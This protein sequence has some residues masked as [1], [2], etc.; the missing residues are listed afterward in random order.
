MVARDSRSTSVAT[1]TFATPKAGEY[2]VCYRLRGHEYRSVGVLSVAAVLPSTFSPTTV[3][4]GDS[5]HLTFVGKGL[6]AGSGGDAVKVVAPGANCTSANET[7]MLHEGAVNGNHTHTATTTPPVDLR[8]LH[9]VCYRLRGHE[10]RSVGVLSVAAVLPSTFS[11]AVVFAGDVAR[12]SFVGKGL[13]AGS[14][15]DA[16]KVVVSGANC[17]SANAMQT[18]HEGAVHG[19]RT[20][21]N[22]VMPA[23]LTP[24][25]HV[26]CYC[27]PSLQCKGLLPVLHVVVNFQRNTK[28]DDDA[29]AVV[30]V[31]IVVVV[32]LCAMGLAFVSWRRTRSNNVDVERP[33]NGAGG[34]TSGVATAFSSSASTTVGPVPSS[35]ASEAG[36]SMGPASVD[37]TVVETT[38]VG[39][40]TTRSVSSFDSTAATTNDD[41]DEP[42]TANT[43]AT[44]VSTQAPAS[45][46]SASEFSQG[47]STVPVASARATLVSSAITDGAGGSTSSM[48]TASSVSDTRPVPSTTANEAGATTPHMSFQQLEGV[49]NRACSAELMRIVNVWTSATGKQETETADDSSN[50]SSFGVT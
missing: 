20:H 11:P 2:T 26:V 40:T 24:G 12:L 7:Q 4:A 19:N 35:T 38:T 22:V 17:T 9:P 33:R 21:V 23:N 41:T 5:V 1:P 37:T 6:E 36:S 44:T 46:A 10:Y 3:F 18:L 15:G 32:L 42:S 16:V 50:V 29:T 25:A 28:S 30:A 48:A 43:I 14:G 27:T 13:E 39:T 45:L 47:T 8:G 34:S 49:T 31:P